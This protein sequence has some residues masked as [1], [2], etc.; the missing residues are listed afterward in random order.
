MSVIMN[1]GSRSPSS[2]PG[3]PAA[4]P[5]GAT[6]AQAQREPPP[7]VTRPSTLLGTSF[8]VGGGGPPYD[9]Q[10]VRELARRC[11]VEGLYLCAGLPPDLQADLVG[12]LRRSG[13]QLAVRALDDACGAAALGRPAMK[14]AAL[15]A[16]DRDE[17]KVALEVLLA[18][19]E[20]AAQLGS[21]FVTVRLGPVRAVHG[22]WDGLRRRFLR[23]ELMEDAT[24][25][26]EAMEARQAAAQRHLT[27]C[28]RGLERALQRAEAQGVT[29]LLRNPRRA[30]ELPG[31]LELRVLCEEL[32]GAPLS[33]MLDLPAA[34]LCSTM[35]M[36]PLRET[37]NA[38]G[39]GPLAALGDACG[40]VGAL[41]VG[42]GEVNVAPVARA[43]PK[44][45]GFCFLPWAGLI[46]E[47][48]VSGFRSVAALA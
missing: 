36:L 7:K 1:P 39:P 33:P 31:P 24:P 28:L 22:R 16:L 12:V 23:G 37:I 17:A 20:L 27:P 35:R 46:E 44:G 8:M 34:H 14:A 13:D 11:E 30:L 45:T 42:H 29:L 38:F 6:G 3:H 43:L 19:L 41:P 47:E 2:Q 9:G 10:R 32:R 18:A 48:V 25:A 15:G 40:A 21:S 5:A 26:E 4:A